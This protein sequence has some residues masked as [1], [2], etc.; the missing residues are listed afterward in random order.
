MLIFGEEKME[1]TNSQIRAL[2]TALDKLLSKYPVD[3]ISSVAKRHGLDVDT[4]P[5]SLLFR[6][7]ISATE[8][9]SNVDDLEN[10]LQQLR[11]QLYAVDTE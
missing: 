4:D 5:R 11:S 8:T 9:P 10:D 6:L 1:F 7:V 2:D 3:I